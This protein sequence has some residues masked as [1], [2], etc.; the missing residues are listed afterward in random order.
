[1]FPQDGGGD[2]AKLMKEL[3]DAQ[4]EAKK[5]KEEADRL[6]KLVKNTEE[7]HNIKDKLIKELQEW[8]LK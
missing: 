7:E 1:M 3:T 2:H 8:V 5:S 6:L 4:A